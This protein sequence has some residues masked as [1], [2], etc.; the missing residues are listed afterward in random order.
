MTA[1]EALKFISIIRQADV[2]EEMEAGLNRQFPEIDWAD[3]IK[4]ACPNCK[5]RSRLVASSSCL[6]CSEDP[7]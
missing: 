7:D 1:K 3:L 5:R 4:E 6:Y 2:F